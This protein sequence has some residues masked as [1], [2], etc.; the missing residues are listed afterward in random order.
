MS[1]WQVCYRRALALGALTYG[2]SL[3]RSR[4]RKERQ[5]WANVLA[6][7]LVLLTC[8]PV[9][10]QQNTSTQALR[11]GE[12]TDTSSS[13]TVSPTPT[14]QTSAADQ[15][16]EAANPLANIWLLQM[17]QN[18][19]S[20]GQPVGGARMQG[21][22]QF[23]PLIPLPFSDHWHLVVRPVATLF[24]SAPY[25]N[26][27]GTDNRVTRFGDTVFAFGLVPDRTLVGHWL[28]GA[29]PTFIFPTGHSYPLL[30]QNKW[31]FGPTFAVGYNAKRWL[32]YV[33]PQQWFP[34]GGN[35]RKT[36]QML[37]EY[38]FI[39][40]VGKWTVGTKADSF[41]NWQ[42]SAGNKLAFPVGP[43]I[44]RLM[45]VGIMPVK[46]DLAFLYYPVRPSP[47]QFGQ[48]WDLQLEVTPIIPTLIKKKLL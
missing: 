22:L 12:E 21:N 16:K 23:Q 15:A 47:A 34:I 25:P 32:A 30:S 20:V 5:L 6:C 3:V 24:N 7:L 10:A 11:T 37:W 26:P 36:N 28:L 38:S 45:H 1:K 31:Q 2:T 17:Q 48:K 8:L 40:T 27:N 9:S 4:E 39:Y 33:F 44:G 19:W 46:V 18:N 35:G 29:G 42:A 41:V 13:G 14:E 43:K